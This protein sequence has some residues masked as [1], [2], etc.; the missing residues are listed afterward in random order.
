MEDK[1]D[2]FL[3]KKDGGPVELKGKWFKADHIY[4]SDIC[5]VVRLKPISSNESGTSWETEMAKDE[6]YSMLRWF[7]YLLMDEDLVRPVAAVAV[8]EDFKDFG[9]KVCKTVKTWGGDQ[10]WHRG[11]FTFF[12]EENPKKL[13]ER[14]P[15]L[16]APKQ[17][18]QLKLNEKPR[19]EQSILEEIERREAEYEDQNTK[20]WFEIL[21]KSIK[22]AYRPE[23]KNKPVDVTK[24][25]KEKINRIIDNVR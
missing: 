5:A 20:S 22:E 14:I 6:L 23:N 3:L 10:D 18:I 19:N 25:F 17:D 4:L 12:L 2:E 9:N 7:Y 21:K 24:Y 8:T 1:I 13:D 15:D 11:S 16:L